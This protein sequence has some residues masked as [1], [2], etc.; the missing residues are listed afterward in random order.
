MISLCIFDEEE[1]N[2]WSYVI[3]QCSVFI[4]AIQATDFPKMTNEKL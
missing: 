2:H 3:Y 1:K 4:F